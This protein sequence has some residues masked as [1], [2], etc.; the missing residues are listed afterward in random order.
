MCLVCMVGESYKNLMHLQRNSQCLL[1]FCLMATKTVVVLYC[2]Y[3]KFSILYIIQWYMHY[4]REKMSDHSYQEGN[5][6]QLRSIIEVY[7]CLSVCECLHSKLTQPFLLILNKQPPSSEK[8]GLE[9][10]RPKWITNIIF[11]SSHIACNSFVNYYFDEKC[12]LKRTIWFVTFVLGIRQLNTPTKTMKTEECQHEGYPKALSY[13]SIFKDTFW[14]FL[15][16]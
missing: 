13:F 9:L 12:Y 3:M 7:M 5:I 10:I 15:R 8:I 14:P 6:N 4:T 2:I 16:F 1:V 11:F